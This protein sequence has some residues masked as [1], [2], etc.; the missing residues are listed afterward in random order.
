LDVATRSIKEELMLRM[1][2]VAAAVIAVV[3]VLVSA[4]SAGAQSAATSSTAPNA[5]VVPRGQPVQIAFVG[6]SDF[7]DFTQAFRSAIQM[8]I[9]QHP[10]IRGYPIQINES[11]PACFSGDFAAANV[12]AATAVVSN[13]QNTAVIGHICSA[14]FA[15]ALPIYEAADLVTIS[16]SATADFLPSLGPD[17]FNRTAVEDPSFDAWYALVAALPS[18]LAFQQDYQSEFGTPPPPFTDLYFDAA[19]LL[20]SDLQQ[21]SRVVDGNLVIDRA[22]LASAVRNT[23]K[24]QGVT[25]TISLDPSTGN[26]VDDPASLARCAEG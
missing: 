15:P 7:P 13:P 1:K 6:S 16:G 20:L 26:R 10:M 19:S 18:D 24:F 21:V 9:E 23:T 5:V 12:A 14:G 8:A 11:D 3:A 2:C 4:A 25:C 22:A 17:V